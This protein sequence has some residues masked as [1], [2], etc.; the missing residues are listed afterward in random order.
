MCFAF[1]RINRP[2]K[3]T[4]LTANRPGIL[5]VVGQTFQNLNINISEATCRAHDDGRAT[6]SFTF[7]CASLAEL[8]NIVRKLQRIDGV[9]QV[10]R[11]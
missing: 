4:V 3:L 6:N 10:D 8:K 2:V 11:K 5:A 1:T 7:L 9:I